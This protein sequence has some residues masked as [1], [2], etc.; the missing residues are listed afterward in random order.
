MF[1]LKTRAERV[2]KLLALTKT[3]ACVVKSIENRKYLTGLTTT[4]GM[5]IVTKAGNCYV[6][7]DERYEEIATRQLAP[8]GFI[9]KVILT[10]L[11][12]VDFMNDIVQSDK[13]K[14]ML[15][16]SSGISHEDYLEFETAMYAKVMPL[17]TQLYKIR[18]SKDL[19]EVEN[20][21]TAQRINEKTFDE[22][23]EFIKPGMTER[24]IQ[25]KLVQSLLENGSDLDK[26]HICC[27]SGANSS[28]I[29]GQA[30][31][32]VITNGECLL[33][34]FGAIYGGYKSYLT[35]TISIGKPSSEFAKAYEVVKNASLIGVKYI[36]NGNSCKNADTEVRSYIEQM[37]YGG[38]FR[39]SSG[40]GVGLDFIEAP[41]IAQRS[42][43]TLQV[44]NVVTL[45]PGIY[46]K[47]QFGIR[48]CDLLYIG[49][50][51]TENLTRAPKDLII[52]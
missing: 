26:F 47:G 41:V 24:Q 21:K 4:E 22:I 37:G 1:A 28:L 15:L 38:N 19:E 14:S 33:L 36:H 20:I 25:A 42:T 50:S 23:L 27:V 29:H 18:T 5:V 32:K 48:I 11:N 3:D 7:V 52:I 8:Q 6:L 13:I 31:D 10:P 40:H 34:D 17:K 12:Y 16:E 35:R 39:H 49:D 30:S 2:R 45:E 44:G 43:E 9:I 46:I 51:G